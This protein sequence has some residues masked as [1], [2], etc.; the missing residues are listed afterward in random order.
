MV[1]N[2]PQAEVRHPTATGEILQAA[3]T[4]AS[5]SFAFVVFATFQQSSV[6]VPPAI[7]NLVFI[8]G[9]LSLVSSI[10]C[11]IELVREQGANLSDRLFRHLNHTSFLFWG[12]LVL[13]VGYFLML[14]AVR[15]FLISVL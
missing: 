15:Q 9:A 12:L 10:T 5:I 7:V 11:L 14:P 8:A 1:V 3:V 4:V 2:P 13:A 6:R